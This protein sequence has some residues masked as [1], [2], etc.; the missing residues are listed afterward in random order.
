MT[1]NNKTTG[2]LKKAEMAAAA[3]LFCKMIILATM[4]TLWCPLAVPFFENACNYKSN[5]PYAYRKPNCTISRCC[6]KR[7]RA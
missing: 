7:K 2:T 4:S 1:D 6:R 5:K 3:N